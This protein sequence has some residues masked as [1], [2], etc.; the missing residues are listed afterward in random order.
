MKKSRLEVQCPCCRASLTVDSGSGDVIMHRE[1]KT[2]VTLDLGEA[3]QA[4]RKDAQRREK[5]FKK[6]LE[7]ERKKED[8][9]QSKFEE[10]VRRAKEEPDKGP[11]PREIDLD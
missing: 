1:V 4:L 7:A 11:P 6:S 3:A 8:I 9:L 2:N 10:A 5:D